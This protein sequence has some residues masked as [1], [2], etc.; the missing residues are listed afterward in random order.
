MNFI[1]V[2][3][4]LANLYQGD[5]LKCPIVTRIQAWNVCATGQCQRQ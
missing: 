4:A 5:Y 1:T 2:N 3:N